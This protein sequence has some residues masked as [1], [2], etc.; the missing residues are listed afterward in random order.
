MCF[1]VADATGN[2]PASR[3]KTLEDVGGADRRATTYG[4]LA[5]ADQQAADRWF[6]DL[7]TALWSETPRGGEVGKCLL[8]R[9]S[10]DALRRKVDFTRL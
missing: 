8:K 10:I 1:V 7:A 5:A 3:E 2:V 6:N 9:V 4:S